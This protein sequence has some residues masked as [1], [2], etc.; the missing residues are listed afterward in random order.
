MIKSNELLPHIKNK[1][2]DSF[3]EALIIFFIVQG[4]NNDK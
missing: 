2:T 4:N 1:H 3:L